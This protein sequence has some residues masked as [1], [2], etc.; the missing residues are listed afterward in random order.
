MPRSRSPPACRHTL[1][2]I[3]K[4]GLGCFFIGGGSTAV[5]NNRSTCCQQG[6]GAAS[7]ARQMMGPVCVVLGKGQ[8]SARLELYLFFFLSQ[9][10]VCLICA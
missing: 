8:L 1:H 9:K 5:L 6:G 4:A 10:T 3:F 7:A 2:G